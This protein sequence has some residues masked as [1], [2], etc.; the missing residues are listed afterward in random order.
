MTLK[1]KT[2][3][4][5]GVAGAIGGA[6]IGLV[7][8]WYTAWSPIERIAEASK[9]GAGTGIISGLAVGMES[10]V[11]SLLIVAGVGF[12]AN[13]VMPEGMGLFGI[14]FALVTLLFLPLAHVFAN[15]LESSRALR[16]GA[17]LFRHIALDD[18]ALEGVLGVLDVEVADK[19]LGDGRGA[20]AYLA[21]LEV[22]ERGSGDRNVVDAS[23]LVEVLVFD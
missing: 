9:T 17:I 21:R 20:L 19:L 22:L 12:V 14:A 7:T 1:G 15:P 3:L 6:L 8:E 23:V 16:A 18:L 2:A 10:T 5:T 4:V 13:A 11:V